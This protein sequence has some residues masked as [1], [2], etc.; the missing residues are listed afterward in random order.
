MFTDEE[1]AGLRWP[2]SGAPVLRPAPGY[3][4]D[5]DDVTTLPAER[6][7]ARHRLAVEVVDA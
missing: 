4:D 2:A 1:L 7:P 5:M 6:E 3:G